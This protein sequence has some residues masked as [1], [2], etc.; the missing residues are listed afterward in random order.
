MT[1]DVKVETSYPLAPP[2]E[3]EYDDE[4]YDSDEEDSLSQPKHQ[5]AGGDH[6][7]LIGKR[8]KRALAH[9]DDMV[10]DLSSI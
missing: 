6:D 1:P 8:V 7:A 2:V 4:D 9:D 5:R 3:D 10:G